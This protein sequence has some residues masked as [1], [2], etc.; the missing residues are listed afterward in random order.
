MDEL[1]EALKPNGILKIY[2]PNAECPRAAWGDPGHI[3]A[4]SV[5]T[6]GYFTRQTLVAF[7]VTDKPWKILN[8]YPKVNGVAPDDLWELEWWMTPDKDESSVRP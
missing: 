3:G 8:G 4:F 1:W 7:P 2:V 5:L 6:F